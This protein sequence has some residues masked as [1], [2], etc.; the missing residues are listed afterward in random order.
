MLD[1]DDEYEHSHL[2]LR[3]DFMNK[4]KK[5]DLLHSPAKLIGKEEDMYLPDA[6]NKNKLIH[7]NECVIGATFFGKREVFLNLKGFKDKYSADSDFY[8]RAIQA[9]YKVENLDSPTYIYYRNLPDS[10]TNKL[11]IK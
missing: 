6:R 3:V 10:V 2:K 9:G 4:N 11:K 7:I 8:K 5:I 1:S